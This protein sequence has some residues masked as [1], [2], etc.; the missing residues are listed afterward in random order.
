MPKKASYFAGFI[1]RQ[2]LLIASQIYEEGYD[3]SKE[4]VEIAAPKT[5]NEFRD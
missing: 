5:Q 4:K 1:N 3:E 2:R